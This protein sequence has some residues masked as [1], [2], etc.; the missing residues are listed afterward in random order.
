MAEMTLIANKNY[1]PNVLFYN[2]LCIIR[3]LTE[4][5]T[6][7]DKFD[8]NLSGCIFLPETAL[9]RGLGV[10]R[11]AGTEQHRTRQQDI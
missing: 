2:Q 3:K 6:K 9:R 11:A 1:F 4:L 7:I 8:K 5:N 10:Q